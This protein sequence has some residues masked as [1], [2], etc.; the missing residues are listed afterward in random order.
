MNKILQGLLLQGFWREG[1]GS[2]CEYPLCTRFSIYKESY[3][4][5]TVFSILQTGKLR[6]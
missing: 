4:V 1:E 5:G 2:I 6:L 3:G